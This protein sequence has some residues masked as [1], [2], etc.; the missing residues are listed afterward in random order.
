VRRI[1]TVEYVPGEGWIAR[2]PHSGFE[3]MEH[4]FRWSSRSV[5]RAVVQEAR[6]LGPDERWINAQR[7]HTATKV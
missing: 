6:L 4:G 2:C 7:D 5:A 3:I 1:R